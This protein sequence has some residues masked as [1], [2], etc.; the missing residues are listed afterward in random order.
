LTRPVV[1]SLLALL[2]I[3]NSHLAFAGAFRRIES[4]LSTLRLEWT[5]GDA[6]ARLDVD[7][8]ETS[9]RLLCTGG[10]ADATGTLVWQTAKEA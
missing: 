5:H 2:R 7:L 3:R 9:A 8:E 10:T 6:F 1:Q 4:S